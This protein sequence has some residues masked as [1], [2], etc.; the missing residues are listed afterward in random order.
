MGVVSKNWS[1]TAPEAD[2][3]EAYLQADSKLLVA[4]GFM[5]MGECHILHLLWLHSWL[6][7][8]PLG[9]CPVPVLVTAAQ[10]ATIAFGNST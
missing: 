9:S 8:A 6:S 2:I 7:H 1:G 5:G 3:T 4:K 10:R